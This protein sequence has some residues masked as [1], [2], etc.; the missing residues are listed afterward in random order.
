M[1]VI[2]Y[3]AI[4]KKHSWKRKSETQILLDKLLDFHKTVPLW[5]VLCNISNFHCTVSV[6]A[7]SHCK[8]L[9]LDCDWQ[10]AVHSIQ[11]LSFVPHL[12]TRIP[13]SI[14]STPFCILHA[15]LTI[16]ACNS[17]PQPSPCVSF[18]ICWLN[19]REKALGL[20]W[21]LGWTDWPQICTGWSTHQI[22]HT[23]KDQ[24]FSAF[25]LAQP[26]EIS[27]LR[28]HFQVRTAPTGLG[29]RM[30]PSILLLLGSRNTE[31]T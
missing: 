13:P 11:N 23:D 22:S 3:L 12:Q 31:A 1:P 27:P 8:S 10:T 28:L 5:Q 6:S 20:I 2:L 14:H 26:Q 16:F 18:H 25:P 15:Q 19:N 24:A 17:S 7:K 4:K 21:N 9:K 30:G 29:E